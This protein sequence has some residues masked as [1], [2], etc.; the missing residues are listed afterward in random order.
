MRHRKDFVRTGILLALPL[1][2]L[3]AGSPA[4]AAQREAKV[5]AIS[6]WDA[7]CS[8]S[9]RSSWDDMAVAWYDEITNPGFSFW[10]MCVFGHCGEE[11]SRDGKRVNGNVRNGKFADEDAVSFGED[12][13]FLDEADA[14]LVAWHG[15]ENGSDYQGS[16]RV[17][18][19]GAGDCTLLRSEMRLGDSDLEF[20]HISSCQSMDD[21]QWGAWWQAF[22]GA[23]QVDGFHGLMW[24]GPGLVG[25][26]SDFAADAFEESIAD[27][28]LDNMYVEDISGTDDQC[29]VAYAVA[30]R[31][32][33]ACRRL[34]R[35]RYNNVDGSDPS[36]DNWCAMY[37]TGCDPAA[38]TVIGGDFSR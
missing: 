27:A 13:D 24:I 34:A 20:L 14:A 18:E 10:G 6:D 35:E 31:G 26:Y 8:G 21:N 11:Y 32:D 19:V 3:L 4:L 17:D 15:N 5:Y 23:H 38:E 37:F 25:D 36:P 16:M 1:C 2:A 28:W 29:P 12:T 30:S 33:D 7:G 22:D 9:Q